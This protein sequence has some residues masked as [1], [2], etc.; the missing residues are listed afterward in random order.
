MT[1]K[2]KSNI[3]STIKTGDGQLAGTDDYQSLT[4]YFIVIS[5]VLFTITITNIMLAP[6]TV[7][8]KVENDKIEGDHTLV[9]NFTLNAGDL[10]YTDVTLSINADVCTSP[11]CVQAA[12][13]L[14]NYMD[15]NVSLCEDFY[16]YSCG[17]WEKTHSL[18]SD[19]GNWDII[20]ELAQKNYNYFLNLLSEQPNQ[21]DL[22]AIVK[23][24]RIFTACNNSKQIVEDELEA[25]LTSQVDGTG[26][27]L[28]RTRHGR[29]TLTY[30]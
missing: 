24:K 26:L 8:I 2:E 14:L 11:D 29:L 15:S 9:N 16:Q 10:E 27:M 17:G 7:Y 23:A 13:R 1:P 6:D 5:A 3:W 19:Q 30:H 20:G 21:N 18:P 22:D 28:H 12:A 25:L 4:K